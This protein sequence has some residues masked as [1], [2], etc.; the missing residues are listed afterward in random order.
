MIAN[1]LSIVSPVAICAAIGFFWEKWIRPI[2]KEFITGLVMFVGAPCLIID[3]FVRAQLDVALVVDYGGVVLL[4]F[5]LMAAVGKLSLLLFGLK[6]NAYLVAAC[7]PNTGNMGLPL[8]LLAFGETGLAYALIIFVISAL[9][10]FT[11]GLY[12]MQAVRP[13]RQMLRSPIIHAAWIA[14]LLLYTGWQ[15]PAWAAH[16]VQMLGAISIPLMLITLGS[17]LAQLKIQ[18]LKPALRIAA[19]RIGIGLAVAVGV[20]HMMGVTG[21]ARSALIVQLSMPVAVFNYLLAI[22]YSRRV[23]DLAGS[24]V[25]STLIAV[26]S[27]PLVL[28]FLA[29]P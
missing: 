1:L 2:D 18:R 3:T 7:F 28:T 22:R 4:A 11:F 26:L 12:L 16:T 5:V 24:V 8:C 14:L 17:T 27:V 19:V 10:Q 25:V 29:G 15:M 20:T 13:M 9:L 23:D 6:D 21:T